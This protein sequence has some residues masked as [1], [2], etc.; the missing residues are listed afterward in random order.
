MKYLMIEGEVMKRW[1]IGLMAV[2]TILQEYNGVECHLKDTFSRHFAHLLEDY[3]AMAD[4]RHTNDCLSP[5]TVRS[6]IQDHL[7]PWHVCPFCQPLL[8]SSMWP[9]V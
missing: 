9:S 4:R 1:A 8:T 3:S 6:P 2:V 7:C 5:L